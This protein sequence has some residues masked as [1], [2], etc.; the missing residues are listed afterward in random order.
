MCIEK[1]LDNLEI[2]LADLSVKL[3]AVLVENKTLKRCMKDIYEY[4]LKKNKSRSGGG[5]DA[6]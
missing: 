3:D 4:G 5:C 1:K 2:L 6:G